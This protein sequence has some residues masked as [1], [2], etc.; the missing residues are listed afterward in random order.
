MVLASYCAESGTTQ[1]LTPYQLEL[2]KKGVDILSP[3]EEI[4]DSISADLASISIVN[5]YI[6]ILTKTLER[7]KM[8][9]ASVQ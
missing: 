4:T 1:Q 5:P 8:T 6:R 3:I 2:M 9:V 7:I